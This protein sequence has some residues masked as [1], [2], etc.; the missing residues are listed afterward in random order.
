MLNYLFRHGIA[1]LSLRPLAAKLGTSPRM[2]MFHFKS[3]EGLLQETLGE[4]HVRMLR[5]FRTMASAHPGSH[6]EPLLK[7]FWLWSASKENLP[8]LR[9]LYEMQV[10]AAQNPAEYG[11]YLRTMSTDWQAATLQFLSPSDRSEPMATLCIAVFDGLFL[12]LMSTGQ[13]ARLTRALDHFIAMARESG[14]QNGTTS[15]ISRTNAKGRRR[16]ASQ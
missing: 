16:R 4:L 2:L 5:S 13:R 1:K 9:L 3:K 12:E 7:R 11:R 6:P 8:Y 14:G 15:T 10:I